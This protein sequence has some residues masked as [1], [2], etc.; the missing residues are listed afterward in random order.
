VVKILREVKGSY[1]KIPPNQ[2]RVIDKP[3]G[4]LSRAKYK[5]ITDPENPD[6]NYDVSFRYKNEDYSVELNTPKWKLF[7]NG[8]FRI[9][10]TNPLT[11]K[12]EFYVFMYK[13]KFYLSE[14][15]LSSEDFRMVLQKEVL[16]KKDKYY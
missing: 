2:I 13:S 9:S 15:Y 5:W 8:K 3:A 11:N 6:P 4:F 14:I 16:S 10:H 7:S 1:E 12:H